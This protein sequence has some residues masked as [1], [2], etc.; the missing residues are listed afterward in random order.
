MRGTHKM[1]GLQREIPLKIPFKWMIWGYPPFMGNIQIVILFHNVESYPRSRHFIIGY[2]KIVG[3]TERCGRHHRHLFD[4]SQ[5]LTRLN[6][7]RQVGHCSN[8]GNVIPFNL[9]G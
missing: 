5:K 3:S 8:S 4:D 1:D 6:V 7:S 2:P 9:V